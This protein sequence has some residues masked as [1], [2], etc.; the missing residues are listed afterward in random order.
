MD[1]WIYGY[2]EIYQK[3]EKKIELMIDEYRL[4]FFEC[5]IMLKKEIVIFE[6]KNSNLNFL[7]LR[8]FCEKFQT[9]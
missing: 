5:L 2:V 8:F 7:N 3:S 4:L 9:Y 6:L 1:L